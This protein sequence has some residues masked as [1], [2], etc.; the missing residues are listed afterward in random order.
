MGPGQRRPRRR[1]PAGRLRAGTRH[2]HRPHARRSWSPPPKRSRRRAGGPGALPEGVVDD[3]FKALPVAE[4]E[5][6]RS[7]VSWRE[8]AVGAYRRRLGQPPSPSWYVPSP[9][10]PAHAKKTAGL[11]RS[12]PACSTG[13]GGIIGGFPTLL[14]NSV[15]LGPVMTAAMTLNP[16]AAVFFVVLVL[17]VTTKFGTI[18]RS[19]RACPS[20]PSRIA[21][22]SSFSWA[23][24]RFF[25]AP[26]VDCASIAGRATYL[27]EIWTGLWTFSTRLFL[28]RVRWRCHHRS[29]G[30]HRFAPI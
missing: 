24:P 12:P 21:A 27:K 14:H 9:G 22:G 19:A 28:T 8:D 10:Q 13:C 7:V 23:A 1:D 11:R 4:R 29:R 30:S 2:P 15:P 25:A 18:P 5:P 17:I 26:V 20:R 3:V 16:L 6:S